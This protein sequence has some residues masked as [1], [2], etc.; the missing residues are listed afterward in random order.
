[1]Y[2]K[3]AAAMAKIR[4]HHRDFADISFYIIARDTLNDHLGAR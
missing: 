2:D 1:M 4:S 3:K